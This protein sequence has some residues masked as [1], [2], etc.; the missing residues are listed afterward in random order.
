[1]GKRNTSRLDLTGEGSRVKRTR[2]GPLGF[3][4][5]DSAVSVTSGP[6]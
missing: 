3:D 5:L 6:Q 4:F 1:M 2:V